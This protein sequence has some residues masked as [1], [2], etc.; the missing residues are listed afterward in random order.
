[1]LRHS[2][3]HPHLSAYIHIFGELDYNLT[4]IS[5]EGTRVVIQNRTNDKS[6]WAPHEE[7]GWYIRPA[8]E[9]YRY[10]NS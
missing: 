8:I 9:H 2:I 3:F 10:H 4:P 7:S 5:P 6:S 1:M